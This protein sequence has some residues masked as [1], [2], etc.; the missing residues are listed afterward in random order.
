MCSVWYPSFKL[1]TLF[2]LIAGGHERREERIQSLPLPTSGS[3]L[4]MQPYNACCSTFHVKRC[5][6]QLPL[7]DAIARLPMVKPRAM[8]FNKTTTSSGNASDVDAL[9]VDA[10]RHCYIT[11]EE[12]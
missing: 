10:M 3:S 1:C 11:H 8:Q 6:D 5:P 9:D 7:P 12:M 4:S 2:F